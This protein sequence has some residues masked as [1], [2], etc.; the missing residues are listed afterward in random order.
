MDVIEANSSHVGYLSD[1]GSKSFID[2]YQSTLPHAELKQYVS[3]AFSE[4]SIRQEID[5]AVATYF[6]CRD[7]RLNPC[8]Y[9]KLIQSPAPKSVSSDSHIE[10]Q[11]LYV[12]SEYRRLGI[13]KLLESHAESYAKSHNI[14]TIWLR[15]WEGNEVARDIY[16]N[17]GFTIVGDEP[18]EVGNEKRMVL[19]MQKYLSHS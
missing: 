2:A 10:L 1:F 15:V 14:H 11:R 9:A 17:W 8:G 3:L 16:K 18:Y 7:S 19:V 12:D 6:I 5:R 13:G 4:S